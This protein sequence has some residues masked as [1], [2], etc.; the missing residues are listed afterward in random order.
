MTIP[1]SASVAPDSAAEGLLASVCAVGDLVFWPEGAA[2]PWA[3]GCAALAMPA[4]LKGVRPSSKVPLDG[5]LLI[6]PDQPAG[7]TVTGEIGGFVTVAYRTTSGVQEVFGKREFATRRARIQ[8][9]LQV[10]ILRDNS[11]LPALISAQWDLTGLANLDTILR[12][13]PVECV[14]YLRQWGDDRTRFHG[15]ALMLMA[16]PRR[17]PVPGTGPDCLR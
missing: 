2:R 11:A 8:L 14:K 4:S 3:F 13:L 12:T 7:Q 9:P 10:E 1:I 15:L 5:F 17:Q 16:A 6:P